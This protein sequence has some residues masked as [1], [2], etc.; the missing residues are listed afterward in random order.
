MNAREERRA[1]EEE[2]LQLFTGLLPA[3]CAVSALGD[4]GEELLLRIET[5][6]GNVPEAVEA[7]ISERLTQAGMSVSWLRKSASTYARIRTP[8]SGRTPWVN[9]VMFSLTCLSVFFVPQ[10]SQYAMQ[11]ALAQNAIPLGP[12]DWLLTPSAW[13]IEWGASFTFWLLFI[14][15]AH[16]FGHYIAGRRRKLRLSLPFFIPF[17]SLI[18]TMGAV[19]LFRSA[20]ENRRDLIEIGAAG[21]IAGFL[22]ALVAIAVGLSQTDTLAPGTFAMR[23][24]SLMMTIMANVFLGDLPSNHF[25]DLHPAAFAGW[26]GLLITALN[27]L[28][29]GQLDGGHIVFGLFGK[30]QHLVSKFALAALVVAGY[31]WPAWWLYGALALVFG[32]FHGPTL[33]DAAPLTR[34]ARAMGYTSLVIFILSVTLAPLG[35]V[36]WF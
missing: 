6:R 27:L 24:E 9:I 5:D 36:N 3:G 25:F 11:V 1:R 30:R 17:P 34:T 28:P 4:F 10:Y 22:V 35:D 8:R 29:L 15:L 20:I 31:F 23:G 21:P 33:D 2:V 18:G 26:V 7:D 16:E 19:I 32:P 12:I 13:L 14:L